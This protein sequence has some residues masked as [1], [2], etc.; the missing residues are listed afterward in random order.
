VVRLLTY[1][2]HQP[3]GPAYE[4][5]LP[6]GSMDGSLQERFVNSPAAGLVHAKTGTLSHVNAL[7]GYVHTLRGRRLVFSIFVNN[8]NLPSRK[9]LPAID[10]IVKLLAESDGAK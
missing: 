10:E 2:A 6:V 5:S 9:A 8:H 7:S 3:W 1:A 4:E